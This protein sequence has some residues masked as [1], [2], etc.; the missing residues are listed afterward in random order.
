M[1]LETTAKVRVSCEACGERF[2]APAAK[3]GKKGPCP[4]CGTPIVIPAP[5]PPPP[6]TP[7]DPG[8]I[9]WSMLADAAESAPAVDAPPATQHVVAPAASPARKS[10]RSVL[11]DLTPAQ[12]AALAKRAEQ[13]ASAGRFGKGSDGDD[14]LWG[15]PSF[16]MGLTLAVVGA[17]LGAAIWF[18]VLAGTGREL[19][20]LA[21]LV[22]ALTGGGMMLGY[23]KGDAGTGVLTACLAVGG[24]LLAK[25]CVVWFGS[26]LFLK[27]Q[28]RVEANEAEKEIAAY[29]EE[30]IPH[31]EAKASAFSW[32]EMRTLRDKQIDPSTL[33]QML[34]HQRDE[35]MFPIYDETEALSH[36][37]ALAL[38]RR[39]EVWSD[40]VEA[41]RDAEGDG[42]SEEDAEE[43]LDAEAFDEAAWE[44]EM[45]ASAAREQERS[46]AV[47]TEVAALDDAKVE[48]LWNELRERE[49]EEALALVRTAPDDVAAAVDEMAADED[50]ADAMATATKYSV[51]GPLDAIFIFVA[52]GTAFK[53]GAGFGKD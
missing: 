35:I 32:I 13:R 42:W 36:E 47:F 4:K 6:P 53:M 10:S 21:I 39:Y 27:A 51:F 9:D 17:L 23:Q 29:Y 5:P 41:R 38:H 40:R 25:M 22:G 12:R 15:F 52:L 31:E 8:D 28:A 18:G 24:I 14:N 1:S 44:A 34:E 16:L 43:E 11:A 30:P 26:G 46:D 45:E 19:R 33:Y 50:A 7:A 2:K 49:K 3:A 20:F 48:T 37:Q